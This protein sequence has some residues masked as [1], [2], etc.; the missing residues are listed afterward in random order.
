[1]LGPTN[2]P[3]WE[4][5]DADWRWV[6]GVNF[7]G[8]VN[9]LRQFVPHLLTRDPRR[10]ITF[11]QFEHKVIT[12]EVAPTISSRYLVVGAANPLRT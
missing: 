3:L 2:I 9:G 12:R 6:F 8:V 1:M 4:I 11:V 5:T 7:W 10:R